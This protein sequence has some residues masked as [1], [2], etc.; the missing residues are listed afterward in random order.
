MENKV[1][2]KLNGADESNGVKI[3]ADLPVLIAGAGKLHFDTCFAPLSKVHS[4]Y[5]RAV[6]SCY[7]SRIAKGKFGLVRF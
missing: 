4:N 2:D 1:A 3:A 5:P 7:C 6:W